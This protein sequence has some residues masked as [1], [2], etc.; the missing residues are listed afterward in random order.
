MDSSTTIQLVLSCFGRCVREK[1]RKW[2]EVCTGSGRDDDGRRWGC[3][4]D[5]QLLC[6]W[7]IDSLPPLSPRTSLP[8]TH[9]LTYTRRHTLQHVHTLVPSAAHADSCLWPPQLWTCIRLCQAGYGFIMIHTY[10]KVLWRC[11]GIR[12]YW[13]ITSIYTVSWYII[14]VLVLQ[15]YIPNP[16]CVHVRFNRNRAHDIQVYV[17]Y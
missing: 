3:Q 1:L 5:K 12:W 17:I 14:M 7:Q 4:I 2:M 9:S 10:G 6:D 8:H 15:K 13:L 11:H 16:A